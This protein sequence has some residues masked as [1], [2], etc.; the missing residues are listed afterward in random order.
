MGQ[1]AGDEIGLVLFSGASFIQ[2]PLTNDYNTARTFLDAVRPGMISRPGSDMADAIETAL[3]GFDPNRASQKVIVIMT[4]GEEHQG[5]AEAVA[6][7]MGADGVIIYT[8]GFGNPRGEPIPEYDQFGDFVGHKVD[9]EGK[10]VLSKLNEPTLQ[11]IAAAG[12]GRYFR[13]T[14][15]GGELEQLV[16]EIDRLQTVKLE[17]TVDSRPIERF[18]GFL[19]GALLLFFVGEWIPEKRRGDV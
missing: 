9:G 5:E 13:A 8:I 3:E 14:T 1:L 16:G 10:V 6:E 12:N 15:G 19:L 18:Q 11:R 4:D 17:S 2:F 7:Q